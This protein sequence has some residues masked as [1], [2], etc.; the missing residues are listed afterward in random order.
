MPG[1]PRVCLA[2][3]SFMVLAR[4]KLCNEVPEMLVASRRCGIAEGR[5]ERQHSSCIQN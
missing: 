5:R 4:T 3:I 1:S 2:G